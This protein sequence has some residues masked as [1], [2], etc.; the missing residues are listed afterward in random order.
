MA[1]YWN[2]TMNDFLSFKKVKMSNLEGKQMNTRKTDG[3][4]RA[5]SR[6]F[7]GRHEGMQER[8]RKKG[9]TH[10]DGQEPGPAY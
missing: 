7:R 8:G 2:E 5:S 4:K 1:L 3:L 6:S 10:Q 9:R